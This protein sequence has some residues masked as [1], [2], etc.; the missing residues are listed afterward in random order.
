MYELVWYSDFSLFFPSLIAFLNSL[1]LLFKAFLI[2]LDIHGSALTLIFLCFESSE[3]V[4]LNIVSQHH[5]VIGVVK[6]VNKVPR[7]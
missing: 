7:G 1:N 5:S 4:P 2:L 6:D 3:K